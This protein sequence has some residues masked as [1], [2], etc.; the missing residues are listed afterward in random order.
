MFLAR[1]VGR[2]WA[3]AKNENYDGVPLLIVQPLDENL[4]PAGTPEVSID[5]LGSGEG[6]IVWCE[7]GK[8]AAYA[9]PNTYG[10]SD[11]SIVAKVDAV[12][13]AIRAPRNRPV[14]VVGERGDLASRTDTAA[15][16]AATPKTASPSKSKSKSP[17]KPKASGGG[18]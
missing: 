6:E 8:E 11:S 12:D 10:P 16:A 18:K 14:K 3:S 2:V 17:K 15:N 9:L 5:A 7:G 4:E 13:V 1:I